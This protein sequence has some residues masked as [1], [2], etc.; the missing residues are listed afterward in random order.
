VSVLE[1]NRVHPTEAPPLLIYYDNIYCVTPHLLGVPFS[2][3][4]DRRSHGSYNLQ[5]TIFNLP[6]WN[7]TLATVP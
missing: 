5:H 7:M 2:K 1:V 6:S 4:H 3:Q